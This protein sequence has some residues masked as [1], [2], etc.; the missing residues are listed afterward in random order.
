MWQKCPPFHLK[1]IDW[2]ASLLELLRCAK[3]FSGRS[4]RFLI[5][6]AFGK[7]VGLRPYL[8]SG[9]KISINESKATIQDLIN[10]CSLQLLKTVD[11]KR[12]RGNDASARL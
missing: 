6:V 11:G 3:G 8:S 9:F 5:L 2:V 7:I 10:T 12:H 1:I 4:R